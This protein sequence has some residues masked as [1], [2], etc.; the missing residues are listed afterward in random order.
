[1]QIGVAFVL[2]LLPDA[3]LWC[4]PR[5]AFGLELLQCN[6][7]VNVDI[8]PDDSDDSDEAD[9]Y[10]DGKVCFFQTIFSLAGLDLTTLNTAN[11]DK[12]SFCTN[13]ES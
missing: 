2:E 12:I 7:V 4:G 8:V 11:E 6:A 10:F 3:E 9:G 13:N 1:L 5:L